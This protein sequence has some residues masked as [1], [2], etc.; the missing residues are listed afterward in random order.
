[1]KKFYKYTLFLFLYFSNE[2]IAAEIT[3]IRY[4]KTKQNARLVIESDVALVAN[5]VWLSGNLIIK[6]TGLTEPPDNT[7]I[8]ASA[9]TIVEKTDWNKDNKILQ[10]YLPVSQLGFIKSFRLIPNENRPDRLVIDWRMDINNNSANSPPGL[11]SKRILRTNKEK[12]ITLDSPKNVVS[13]IN[14]AKNA[15]TDKNYSLAISLL[16]KI[17]KQGNIE[18]KS[19]AVEFLGVARER[20]YQLAFAKQYYQ[21]FLTD[22][23]DSQYTSRVKQRLN[24]LIGIQ[25]INKK[26]RLREGKKSAN[27]SRSR[28]R[29]SLA[30]DYRQSELV[31][32]VGERRQ[33][34]SQLG[35]DLD[36]RGD[37]Q[38]GGSSL[39]FRLSGGHYQDLTNEGDA[40]NDRLRYA[41]VSWFTD[42]RKY[43]IDV[44][45]QKSRGKGIFGRFDGLLFGYGVNDTQKL[46][47][48]F[49]APVASSKVISLDPERTFF[50]ISYDWED[51]IDN[52]DI[53]VFTL[54]QTIN[55]L[56]DR[57]AVGSEIKYVQKGTSIYGLFDYDIFYSVLNAFLLSGSH[58]TQDKTRYHWSYNQR[59]SP[60]ISTRNALIGQPAD[61]LDELQNLFLTD[62]EILDLA[63]DR[64]LESRTSTFQISR[65][66]NK[67]FDI[68]GNLTW[69][70]LSG[71]PA[72]GGVAELIEPGSQI[73]FNLYLRGARLY[74][75][76]DSNQVGLRVSQ[77]SNSDVWSVYVN[78]QYRWANSWS[79]SGKLQYNDREN[80]NGSGQQSISPSFRIQYQDRT[81]YLYADFGAIFYTNEVSDFSDISTD[82]YFAYLGYRYF[83]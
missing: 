7:L 43:N 27:K 51:I 81:Q 46:N 48:V 44:G 69:T 62:E 26:K 8:A 58:T 33:T 13:L 70:N 50:G 41:N 10:I 17:L 22:Y 38:L 67:T 39:K 68:S 25:E 31:N 60:Y 78:S 74:S 75:S 30:T 76:A 82:I 61:S 53:S 55:N 12:I 5:E 79:V 77:L 19:F 65:P 52:V 11:I 29:G 66:L 6:I 18:Q 28:T 45:R 23:P 59:R 16:S 72:S 73:Y 36:V 56:T 21:R 64:T 35:V 83:F 20:N 14:D 24:A 40:T 34:L 42:D 71:A 1:M 57:Q 3:A 37:Y 2:L 15:L 47:L 54:N 32:D 4:G 80:N 49:G 9:L 63:I